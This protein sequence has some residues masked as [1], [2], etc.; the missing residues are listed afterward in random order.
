MDK[1]ESN[2]LYHSNCDECGSSDANSVYDDGHTYCFS[3]KTTQ[4]GLDDL[5]PQQTNTDVTF[6]TGDVKE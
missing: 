5:K 4:R 2:F 1:Q 3:C 6:I